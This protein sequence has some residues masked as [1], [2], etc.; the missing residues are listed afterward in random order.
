MSDLEKP[1]A[2][3][4]LEMPSRPLVSL[5]FLIV[6]V[7]GAE[8]GDPGEP[9]YVLRPGGL[10]DLVALLRPEVSRLLW[11]PKVFRLVAFDYLLPLGLASNESRGQER[12]FRDVDW[13]NGLCNSS[14]DDLVVKPK[15]EDLDPLWYGITGKA[16]AALPMALVQELTGEGESEGYDKW[17]IREM[18]EDYYEA[19]SPDLESAMIYG[20]GFGGAR[21][22]VLGI[23]NLDGLSYFI[24][25]EKE[26]RAA[27]D[28]Q[29]NRGPEGDE[30]IPF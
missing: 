1:M 16:A 10:P 9:G 4:L 25:R 23:S 27:W 30:D 11:T 14:K 18:G 19:I 20:F 5:A 2:V 3:A 8:E 17:Q 15:R 24:N 12:I 28:T 21:P 29:Y 7:L 6:N 26:K 13:I 22:Q